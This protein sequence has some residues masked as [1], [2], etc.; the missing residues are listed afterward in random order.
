MHA[1]AIGQTLVHR[2]ALVPLIDPDAERLYVVERITRETAAGFSLSYVVRAGRLDFIS[3]GE[4]ELA[5]WSEYAAALSA[6]AIQ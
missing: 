1:Y 6:S 5:P 2:A 4:I 3:Y